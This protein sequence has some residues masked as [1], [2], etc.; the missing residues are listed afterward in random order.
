MEIEFVQEEDR[1]KYIIKSLLSNECSDDELTDFDLV[2]SATNVSNLCSTNK[3]NA[4]E[5]GI[6]N[7]T[8]EKTV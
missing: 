2:S 3:N 8:E 5:Y 7:S 4:N 6:T 1:M